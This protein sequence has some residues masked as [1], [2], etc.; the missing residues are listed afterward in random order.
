M[1]VWGAEE[2]FLPGE[3]AA[4]SG[5]VGMGDCVVLEEEVFVSVE[6]GEDVAEVELAAF[7]VGE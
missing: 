5:G 3:P 2:G 7:Y 4:G 1:L 6:V